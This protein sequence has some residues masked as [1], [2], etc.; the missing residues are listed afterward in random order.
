MKNSV[1]P[2]PN[3]DAMPITVT[4]I[5]SPGCSHC[6]RAREFLKGKFKE[7]HPDVEVEY[8]D[9]TTPQGMALIQK[10]MIFASPGILINSE[11]FS[12]GGFDQE[13]FL[14]KIEE[15]KLSKQSL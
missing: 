14:K 10:H 15:V 2:Q 7:L 13:K 1:I 6:A 12:T 5:T 9:V 8:I 4:E 11:L 3:N